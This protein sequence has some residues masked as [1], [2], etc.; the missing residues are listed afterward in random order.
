MNERDADSCVSR[1]RVTQRE[2]ERAKEK[3]R[4]MVHEQREEKSAARMGFSSKNFA[5]RIRGAQPETTALT[6]ALFRP[7]HE[8]GNQICTRTYS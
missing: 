7:L 2:R 1:I 4:E 3:E 5:C 8:T 6:R